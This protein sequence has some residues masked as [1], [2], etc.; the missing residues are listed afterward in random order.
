[1]G[2]FPEP[3]LAAGTP[4]IE[5]TDIGGA[6]VLGIFRY[7]ALDHI[8]DQHIAGGCHLNPGFAVKHRPALANDQRAIQLAD[9]LLQ[10]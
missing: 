6:S 9:A 10:K 5:V 2:D 8:I 3:S 1:M 4:V 7:V